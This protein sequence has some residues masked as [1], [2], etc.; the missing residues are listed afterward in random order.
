MLTV[1]YLPSLVLWG[2]LGQEQLGINTVRRSQRGRCV[3]LLQA[4][5]LQD[6]DAILTLTSEGQCCIRS[7]SC[8]GCSRVHHYA[9]VKLPSCSSILQSPDMPV[10]LVQLLQKCPPLPIRQVF[11]CSACSSPQNTCSQP[12]RESSLPRSVANKYFAVKREH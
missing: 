8:P 1:T 11:C 10:L 4:R 6:I 5:I 7:C 2:K 12:H 3:Y 9:S